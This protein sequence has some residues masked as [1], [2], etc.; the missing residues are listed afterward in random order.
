MKWHGSEAV[1]TSIPPLPAILVINLSQLPSLPFLFSLTV[2]F[3]ERSF[4]PSVLSFSLYS[5]PSLPYLSFL[6]LFFLYLAPTSPARVCKM[7]HYRNPKQPRSLSRPAVDLCTSALHMPE[8]SSS[9]Y[10]ACNTYILRNKCGACMLEDIM[11]KCFVVKEHL[12]L[13]C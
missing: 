13:S 11:S 10:I 1:A 6:R 4:F 2:Q 3:P 5:I 9:L 7:D 12:R 8:C